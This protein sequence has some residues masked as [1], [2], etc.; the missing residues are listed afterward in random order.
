LFVFTLNIECDDGP[1]PP[2]TPSSVWS[3][4][5]PNTTVI[6]PAIEYSMPGNSDWQQGNY[7]NYLYI[8]ND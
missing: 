3:E 4:Y 5:S 7:K 2:T 1:T 6:E 8:K